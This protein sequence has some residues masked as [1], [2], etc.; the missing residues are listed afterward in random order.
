MKLFNWLKRYKKDIIV[1]IAV[2]LISLL[3]FAIGYITAL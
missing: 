2:V 3:S 1:F